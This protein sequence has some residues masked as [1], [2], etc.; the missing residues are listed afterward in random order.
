M[1]RLS[2]C[3]RSGLSNDIQANMRSIQRT[4]ANANRRPGFGRSAECLRLRNR[5]VSVRA[6]T[7]VGHAGLDSRY[8]DGIA[9]AHVI[10]R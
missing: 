4:L 2:T 9:F 3:C 1:E 5:P 6:A 8:G 10:T 7:N